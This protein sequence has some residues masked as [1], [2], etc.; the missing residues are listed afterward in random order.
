[1]TPEEAA[2]QLESIAERIVPGV[3]AAVTTAGLV[4]ETAAKANASG[5]PGPRAQTGRLRASINSRVDVS[6]P[7]R[8]AAVI[9]SSVEYAGFVEK[10]TSRMPPYP[11]LLPAL[12]PAVDALTELLDDL[13]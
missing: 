3:A 10:G 8:P 12:D 2:A 4:G 11:Y 6:N 5:R 9:G 7:L 1:M 13:I